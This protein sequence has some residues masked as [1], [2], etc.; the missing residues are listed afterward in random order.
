[1][2]ARRSDGRPRR[3]GASGRRLALLA[4]GAL[5]LLAAGP[6]LSATRAI[7]G[8]CRVPDIYLTFNS[9]LPRTERLIS[10]ADPVR[11][12]VIGA[13]AEPR[14]PAVK[15]RPTLQSSLPSRLPDVPLTIIEATTVPATVAQD[16]RQLRVAVGE[17][18]PDLVIWNVGTGDV[19]AG[20]DGEAFEE[21]LSEA[22]EWLQRQGIDLVLVD[23][24]FLPEAR[25]KN[26]YARIVQRIGEL[27][28][29]QSLNVLR[30][31]GATTYLF[32]SPQSGARGG[33][34]VLCLPEL[35][36]EAIGRAALR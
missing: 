36:A 11:I 29:R 26:R 17:A 7:S 24:P 6:A 3:S 10:R 12:L 33:I 21:T 16:F 1:M 4:A 31:N 19:I 15:K 22:V 8:A 20:T 30:Q 28:D 32:S 34:G 35:L 23:P 9:V 14:L 27:S 13:H 5:A 2:G 25:E 18:R